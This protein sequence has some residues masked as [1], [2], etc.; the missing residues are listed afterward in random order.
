MPSWAGSCGRPQRARVPSIRTLG[1]K[2][3]SK[4]C[5]SSGGVICYTRAP[6]LQGARLI[7]GERRCIAAAQTSRFCRTARRRGRPFPS[8][9]AWV[10]CLPTGWLPAD[11]PTMQRNNAEGATGRRI[12]GLMGLGC[13]AVAAARQVRRC[14]CSFDPAPLLQ[15]ARNRLPIMLEHVAHAGALRLARRPPPRPELT[16]P[17]SLPLSSAPLFPLLVARCGQLVCPRGAWQP[18]CGAPRCPTSTKTSPPITPG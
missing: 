10:G 16:T 14:K 5:S 18:R 4:V 1:A 6:G 15:A 9:A 3:C 13:R 17:R 11:Q 7:S 12:A 8:G 2:W